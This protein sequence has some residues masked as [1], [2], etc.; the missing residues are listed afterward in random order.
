MS[1]YVLVRS[2]NVLTINIVSSVMSVLTDQCAFAAQ[3]DFNEDLSWKPRCAQ[4]TRENILKKLRDWVESPTLTAPPDPTKFPNLTASCFWLHGGAG[5]GKSA[6]AQSLAEQL[7]DARNLAASFFFHCVHNSRNDGNKLFPTIIYQ[8]TTTNNAYKKKVIEQ[9]REHQD[10]FHKTLDRQVKVLLTDPLFALHAEGVDP[11]TF[12]RLIVIDGLDECKYTDMHSDI[13]TIIARTIL[14]G[15]PFPFRFLVT[16]RPEGHISRTFE[17]NK[18]IK[19]I[20]LQKYDLSKDPDASRDIRTFL[21]QEFTRLCE[22]HELGSNLVNII[23]PSE[24]ELVTLIGRSSGHFVYPASVIRFIG[25]H[26]H[27]PDYSLKIALGQIPC[28]PNERPFSQLDILYWLILLD[29]EGDGYLNIKRA[30]SILYLISQ[31]IGYFSVHHPGSYRIIEDMLLLRPGDLDLM[32]DPLRSLVAQ[33]GGEVNMYVLHKTLFDF[34]LDPQRSGHLALSK[35]LYHES[36]ALY[37]HNA[38]TLTDW[39]CEFC[40]LLS[41]YFLRLIV[42]FFRRA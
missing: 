6:I 1:A 18:Y 30:F 12:P 39:Y 26:Q 21:Q 5:S 34:L 40:V 37:M 2:P 10:I 15:I 35:Q 23:W 7:N 13:L 14:S 29:V 27:P 3:F 32:F 36:A 25:S 16:S 31:K 8:L 4:S 20:P 22:N 33:N 41:F 24:D 38:N 9:L 28:Q 17:F 11:S 42:I 19:Q